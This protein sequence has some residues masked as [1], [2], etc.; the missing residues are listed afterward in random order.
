MDVKPTAEAIDDNVRI[1][2]H[3]ADELSWIARRMTDRQDISYSADA[4]QAISNCFG[5]LRLDLLVTRPIREL[6]RRNTS[7]TET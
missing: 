2:L 4:L 5:S 6:E 1:L 7:E 3:Y